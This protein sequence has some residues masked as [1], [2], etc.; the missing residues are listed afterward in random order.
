[1]EEFEQSFGFMQPLTNSSSQRKHSIWYSVCEWAYK[2]S[3]CCSTIS[4]IMSSI[5]IDDD[6]PGSVMQ[7]A[8]MT[9]DMN[10]RPEINRN[11]E[12]AMVPPRTNGAAETRSVPLVPRPPCTTA[13][14][15]QAHHHRCCG[16]LIKISLQL[17]AEPPSTEHD[18]VGGFL[19]CQ[20]RA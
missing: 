19:N 12:H 18:Q 16:T 14:S 17:S 15:S 13:K 9:C 8:T 6:D 2:G 20:A 7:L 5:Y 4:P 10:C 3:S 1:M 11:C